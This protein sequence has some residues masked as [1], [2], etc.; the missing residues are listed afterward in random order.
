MSEPQA[1]SVQPPMAGSHPGPG[2]SPRSNG[3]T[4]SPDGDR[5][6]LDVDFQNAPVTSVP[7]IPDVP[8]IQLP[9]AVGVAQNARLPAESGQMTQASFHGVIAHQKRSTIFYSMPHV[10][11]L[12]PI[13]PRSLFCSDKLCRSVLISEQ[14]QKTRVGEGRTSSP[15]G[16][17]ETFGFSRCGTLGS[18]A[19]PN[20]RDL[21]GGSRAEHGA[22]YRGPARLA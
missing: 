21:C 6:L 15:V 9:A 7:A 14:L 3:S 8:D 10:R 16:P 2:D 5:A 18:S 22:S 12:I 20:G 11:Y 19:C 1:D 13:G 4:F 17:V